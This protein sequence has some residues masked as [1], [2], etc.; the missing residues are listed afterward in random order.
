[1]LNELLIAEY[2][3]FYSRLLPLKSGRYTVQS[4]LKSLIERLAPYIDKL[5]NDK[6]FSDYPFDSLTAEINSFLKDSF[7][8]SVYTL[9]CTIPKMPVQS[10]IPSGNPGADTIYLLLES[11]K[12]SN[13]KHTL[14]K[15]HEYTCKYNLLLKIQSCLSDYGLHEQI[16]NRDREKYTRYNVIIEHSFNKE[17]PHVECMLLM[18]FDQLARLFLKPYH[19]EQVI[20]INGI[21]IPAKHY[22]RLRVTSTLLLDDEIENFKHKK[23]V[24][25]SDIAF[26]RACDDQTNTILDETATLKDNWEIKIGGTVHPVHFAD[27]SGSDFEWMVYAYISRID[28]WDSIK[29][30]GETGSDGGRDIWGVKG[31]ES[32]CYQCANHRQLRYKKITGDIDKLVKNKTIPFN[33]MVVCSGP[34]SADMRDKISG[35]AKKAG[36]KNTDVWSGVEFEEKLRK[37][38]PELLRRFFKGD[39]FPEEITSHSLQA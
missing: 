38:T 19:N 36:I 28:E 3:M 18:S 35:Y 26:A 8:T 2:K 7:P 20:L 23:S 16:R 12:T 24:R 25:S 4:T 31:G 27:L 21:K 9:Y 29:W 1:M 32:W 34:V 22:N 6:Y 11:L 30:L 14:K 13:R 37:D 17:A 33:F 5:R 15:V 10:F 39:P